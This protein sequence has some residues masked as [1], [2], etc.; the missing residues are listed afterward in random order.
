MAQLISVILSL[1]GSQKVLSL[2][3]LLDLISVE[4]PST[5]RSQIKS[6]IQAMREKY[7]I[8]DVGNKKERIY[9][10]KG[11]RELLLA[12]RVKIVKEVVT[13]MAKAP[14]L[15]ECSPAKAKL[16][17]CYHLVMAN[18]LKGSISVNYVMSFFDIYYEMDATTLMFNCAKRYKDTIGLMGRHTNKGM[19]LYIR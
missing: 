11:T 19:R 14:N 6:A 15:G 5:S 7:V 18:R 2:S 17:D 10:F 8:T 12:E 16:H 9:E 13:V 4:I 1:F 3:D